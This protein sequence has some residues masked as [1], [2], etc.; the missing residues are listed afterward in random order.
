MGKEEG[1]KENSSKQK[2]EEREVALTK[3]S[4]GARG[5]EGGPGHVQE[6]H[7]GVQAP[8]S[9]ALWA[10]LPVLLVWPRAKRSL[11]VSHL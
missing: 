6:R 4:K 8:R 11:P 1:R 10:Q 5:E 2:P 9:W 7:K 3:T